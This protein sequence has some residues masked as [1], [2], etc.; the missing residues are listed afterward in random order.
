[1]I[2]A[3]GVMRVRVRAPRWPFAPARAGDASWS[4]AWPARVNQKQPAA[5][6]AERGAVTGKEPRGHGYLGGLIIAWV[7][8]RAC[9]NE[10]LSMDSQ[11]TRP[12]A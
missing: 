8:S 10:A 4:R 3:L 9:R 12:F 11:R 2:H 6:R 7:G 1:M 5:A